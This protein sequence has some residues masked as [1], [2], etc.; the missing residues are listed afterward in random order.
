MYA[1]LSRA[2]DGTLT[3]VKNDPAQEA[4]LVLLAGQERAEN[5]YLLEAEVPRQATTSS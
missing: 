5:L 4:R 1:I 2:M 3:M